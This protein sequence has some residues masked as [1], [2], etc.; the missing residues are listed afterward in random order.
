MKLYI[1]YLG[2]GHKA[3]E[4]I[5]LDETTDLKLYIYIILDETTDLKLYVFSLMKL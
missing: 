4:E 3:I 1:Y 2:A 5:I